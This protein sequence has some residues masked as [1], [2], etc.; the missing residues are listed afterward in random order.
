MFSRLPF[1]TAPVPLF[2]PRVR[3]GKTATEFARAG[4]QSTDPSPAGAHSDAAVPPL[5][6]AAHAECRPPKPLEMQTMTPTIGRSPPAAAGARVGAQKS[7]PTEVRHALTLHRRESC[8]LL[9]LFHFCCSARCRKAAACR[10]NAELCLRERAPQVPEP[11]RQW[12]GGLMEARDD[13]LTFDEAR[14]DVAEFEEAYACW[15][16]GLEARAGA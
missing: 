3:P 16:A 7:Y 4:R 10:G 11:V 12:V 8:K 14:E 2:R 13:G 5:A 1:D 15:L 6:A 9:G